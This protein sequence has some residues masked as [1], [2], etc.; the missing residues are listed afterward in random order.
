M[1][2]AVDRIEGSIVVLQNLSNGNVINV[3]KCNLSQE[4]KETD[5][6]VYENNE[7]KLDNNEKEKREESIRE[8]MERLRDNE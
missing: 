2:Y 1:K 5:I 8:K 3:D 6:L 4:V 7:F